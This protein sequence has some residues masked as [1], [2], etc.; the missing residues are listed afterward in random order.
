MLVGLLNGENMQIDLQ[1][2][3]DFVDAITSNDS[4]DTTSFVE[5]IQEFQ[6]QNPGLNVSLAITAAMGMSGEA[7]EF[8]EIFKKII[9]HRKPFTEE[10]RA[11]AAKELGDIVWYWTNACRALALDPNQV[12][13]DNVTKLEARYPG[14]KFSAASSE[15]RVA[16][17]I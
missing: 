6:N 8:S 13:A 4:N 14:G 2:Y 16:G 11:H 1:K 17:D 10:T 9:F 15:T 3:T 5:Y 12:I 7:G